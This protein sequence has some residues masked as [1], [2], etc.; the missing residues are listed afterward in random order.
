M[1]IL[2]CEQCDIHAVKLLKVNNKKVCIKCKNDTI[3]KKVK[4]D[5]TGAFN[6]IQK[7]HKRR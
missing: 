4:H 5:Y 7:M 3:R 2:K 6:S 1:N